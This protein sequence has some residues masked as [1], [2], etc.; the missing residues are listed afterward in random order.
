[1]PSDPNKFLYK[2]FPTNRRLLVNQSI[3][4]IRIKK[5]W[6]KVLIIGVG[7]DPYRNLFGELEHYV[8]LDILVD[9]EKVDIVADAHFLPFASSSF[10]CIMAI[11][12]FEHLEYPE[13]FVNEMHR[14]LKNSG[15]TFIS[16]PFMFHE[17][18]DPSDYWRPTKFKLEK[19]FSQFSK[20]DI[21]SQGNRIHVILD[22]ITTSK[23]LFG[24]LRAFRILNHLIH[25]IKLKKVISSSPSGYFVRAEK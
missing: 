13:K 7:N 6:K 14:V 9:K 1:M 4:S 10:D 8:R 5:T 3:S 24:L 19:I 25:L 17:H 11:E 16:V 12:V 22:L 15:S 20:L 18:G 21:I 2:L 23:S